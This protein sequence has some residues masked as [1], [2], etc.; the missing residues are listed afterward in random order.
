MLELENLFATYKNINGETDLANAYRSLYAIDQNA[1]V[2]NI[3]T[4]II[5][6][7][8]MANGFM[9]NVLEQMRYK[10]GGRQTR[11]QKANLKLMVKE[12]MGENTGNINAKELADAWRQTAE[13][14]RKRANSFGMK[15][16]QELIGD[17][18]NC[19]THCQ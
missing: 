8:N 5:N 1:P 19:M 14:L 7:Q 10:L 18:H 4:Q 16:Y 9:V 15:Y 6:E 11:L 13:H 3:E 17:Y 12:L 2:P